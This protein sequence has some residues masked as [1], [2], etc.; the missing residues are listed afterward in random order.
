MGSKKTE[1]ERVN[2]YFNM[3]YHERSKEMRQYL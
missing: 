2:N 3:F 1:N